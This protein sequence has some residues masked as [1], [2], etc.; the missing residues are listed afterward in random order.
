MARNETI[1]NVEPQRVWDVLADGRL[2]GHWVVGSSEIRSVDPSWPAVGS[3]FHHTVGFGPFKVADNTQIE[4]AQEP[5]RLQLRAKARP[6]GVARVVME[7]HPHTQGT[8][9][10]MTEDAGNRLTALVLN[11]LTHWLVHGR[12][13]ES[14]RRL[15]DLAEG[16]GP[17]PEAARR[18]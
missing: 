18:P 15:K 6:L 10:V 17:T 14:L 9:V 3:R 5:E 2:Y 13:V 12:N 7:L 11:P 8:R 4:Q 1:I 16:R